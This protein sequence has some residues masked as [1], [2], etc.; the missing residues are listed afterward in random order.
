MDYDIR[1]DD[2]KRLSFDVTYKALMEPYDIHDPAM[3]PLAQVSHGGDTVSDTAYA[4]HWDQSGRVTG[5]MTLD[6]KQ[7]PID[8]VSSMDHSWGLRHE[9][10]FANF[11]WLNANFDNDTSIH[12][13]WVINP[14]DKNDYSASSTAMSARATRFMASPRAR[15]G[16]CATACCTSSWTCR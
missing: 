4:G 3:D 10:Q 2:G 7:F 6:G 5:K 11:C 15:A 8:C 16:C 14:D 12:C 13:I 9:D 1:F